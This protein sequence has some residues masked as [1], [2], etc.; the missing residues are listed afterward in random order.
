MLG[1]L[2]SLLLLWIVDNTFFPLLLLL[3]CHVFVPTHAVASHG[4]AACAGSAA[5]LP[6][7]KGE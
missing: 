6:H 7:H 5:A 3:M 4:T 1:G 2:L